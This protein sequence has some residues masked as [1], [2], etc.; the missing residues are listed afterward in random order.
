MR[1]MNLTG[2]G[3][4]IA[5]ELEEDSPPTARKIASP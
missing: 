5:A 3:D 1:Q 4:G 2:H